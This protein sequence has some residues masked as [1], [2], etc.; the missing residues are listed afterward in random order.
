M[1]LLVAG[2]STRA[3]AESA[4]RAG[5]TVTALDAFADLDQHPDVRALSLPREFGA[6]FT[7]P[8]AARAAKTIEV[9]AVAYLSSFEN[10]P[11]AIATLAAGR[12]LLGNPPAVVA[13]VRDPRLV[14]RALRRHGLAAPRVRFAATSQDGWLVKPLTSGGGRGVRVWR[15][16]ARVPRGSYL[17]QHVDGTPG[18]VVFV[19]ASGRAVPIGVT[20]QIV[21]DA[22]FGAAGFQYCGNILAPARDSQ[23][24]D[25]E[26]LLRRASKL[27]DGV[28]EAFGLVGVNG[29]DFVARGGVPY[30]IEVN[31]RWSASMELVERAHELSVFGA[32][33]D[34]C[35]LAV[36]PDFALLERQRGIHATGKA[37]VFAR[38]DV[39]TGE[40]R[41]WIAAGIRDV[42][43]PG[44]R[45][46]AGRPVCTV[47]ADGR[48]AAS[49]Y[50]ELVRRAAAVYS[51][52][53]GW[54]RQVA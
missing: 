3:A 29:V 1:R 12:V 28:A 22:A 20:R 13:R 7:S 54:E 50:R 19:A 21:G 34:A 25:G 38:R 10:H 45:I 23:F 15:G 14:A 42:P 32:H 18:S 51:D 39:T 2:V 9:D 33:A 26:R 41:A 27:A 31:P 40:T 49:C 44:E 46:E 16:G 37:I 47:L 52:L 36:L 24:Q 6:R 5:F 17:Q 11:R 8:A 53:A 35:R 43:H 30:A 48:D 4:A